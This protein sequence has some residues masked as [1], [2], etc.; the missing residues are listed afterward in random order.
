MFLLAVLRSC[1]VDLL[2]GNTYTE[3][4]RERERLGESELL[5]LLHD[6]LRLASSA[7]PA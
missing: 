2:E 1:R 6:S 3:R 7:S 5:L 4:E